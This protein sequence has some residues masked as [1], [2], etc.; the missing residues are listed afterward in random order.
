MVAMMVGSRN[1]CDDAHVAVTASVLPEA[2]R[3]D[4]KVVGGVTSQ[5]TAVPGALPFE[6]TTRYL[7]AEFGGLMHSGP[8]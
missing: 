7:L 4:A 3:H 8:H 2:P 6:V 5:N 1:G